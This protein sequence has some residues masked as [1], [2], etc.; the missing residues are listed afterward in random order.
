MHGHCAN[1][2]NEALQ[3]LFEAETEIDH[4]M[5]VVVTTTQMNFQMNWFVALEEV[6][7]DVEPIMRI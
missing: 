7:R 3:L 1:R 6:Q 4:R 2:V 5:G